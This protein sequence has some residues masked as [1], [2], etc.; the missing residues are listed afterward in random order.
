MQRTG[1]QVERTGVDER[2]CSLARCDHGWLGEAYVVA[3]GHCHAAVLGEID[4]RRLRSRGENLGLLECDLTRDIDVEEMHFAVGV[5]QGARG[6]EDKTGVIVFVGRPSRGGRVLRVSFGDRTTDQVGVCLLSHSGESMEGWG[7]L[8]C[9]R[10]GEQ[11][12]RVTGEMLRAVGRVEALGEDDDFGSLGGS[13]EDLCARVGEV[14]G[15]VGACGGGVS[16]W[17]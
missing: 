1:G 16:I 10:G 7:L 2:E 14:D 3:D 9:G 11:R 12:L 4:N 8:G 6:R 17:H 13:G 15:F 5:E